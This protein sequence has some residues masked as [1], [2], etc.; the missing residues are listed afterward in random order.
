MESITNWFWKLPNI[1]EILELEPLLWTL[2]M[3]WSE[4]KLLE[5]QEIQL[6]SQWDLK[7]WV[8]SLMLLEN[9]SMKEDQSKQPNITQ[10][11]EMPQVSKIKDQVLNYW[12]QELK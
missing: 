2:L 10:S 12:L 9:P 1:W 11:I 8:E 3:V 5:I 6:W 7:L 4:D